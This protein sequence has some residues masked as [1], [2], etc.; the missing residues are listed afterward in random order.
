M[1]ETI[2]SPEDLKKLTLDRKKELATEI[3]SEILNT[4]SKNGGHLSSNL[5]TVELTIA[6]HSVMDLPTDKLIFD[7]GHQCYT[8][9]LLTG[10]REAFHT[11]RQEGGIS[12]FTRINESE[13]DVNCSGHAS[14]SISLAVGMAKARDLAGG[15][16]KIAVLLGDGALSGGMCF[17]ALNDAGQNRTP[18]VI[19]LNDNEMSISPNVG[20]I[21]KYL[22]HMRQSGL[23]RGFKQLVRRSVDKLPSGGKVTR[24]FLTRIKDAFKSLV[25]SDSFFGSLDVEFLGPIDGHDIRELER[26]LKKAFTYDKPVVVHAVTKKGKGYGFAEENPGKY[27]GVNP[28]NIETGEPLKKATP[29]MGTYASEK[30]AEMA[31]GD[32]SIVAI[33]AGMLDGTGLERF[34]EKHDRRCFDVGISEEHAAA[35]AAGLSLRGMRPYL[36]IY[37]TFLQ[38]AYDQISIDVCLNNA[39]V[40]LLIDRAG[41]NGADGET[42]QGVFDVSLL[43]G[44]PNLTICSPATR[45]ELL[46]DMELSLMQNTPFAIRYPK[47]LPEG[48]YKAFEVGQWEE[49]KPIDEITIISFGRMIGECEKAEEILCKRGIAAGIVNARTLKPMDEY[50]LKRVSEHAKHVFTVEDDMLPGSF[51]NAAAGR[52]RS[53]RPDLDITVLALPEAYIAAGTVDQQLK[54]CGLDALSI[55]DKITDHLQEQK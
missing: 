16:E 34:R 42:H 12:G 1:L 37:S 40:T 20:A 47:E 53:Y 5:G 26:V 21:S 39:P 50:M 55:A 54:K 24:T 52:M 18:L 45:R 48:E 19:V 43:M 10:R 51:G 2:S 4:V 30:L 13:Y 14:D 28:F 32:D 25:V 17:E 35:M 11:L 3:R 9:K 7:V 41:L 31:D 29:S 44:L 8:H 36:A 23:Y 15:S 27:H 49:V 38:R 33:T 22:T 6:L 46:R